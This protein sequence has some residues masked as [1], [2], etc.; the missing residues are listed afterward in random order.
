MKQ[1]KITVLALITIVSFASCSDDD[2]VAPPVNEEEVITTVTVTFTPMNGGTAVVLT[3][4][5]LDGDGPNAP[6]VTASGNLIAG[7]TYDGRVTFL[8]E[9][10]SPIE[11]ITEEIDAEG[12]KHQIFYQQTGL[13]DFTYLD[14]DANGNPI[15]LH[16][17]YTAPG[18]TA[19]GPLT[20]TL[21]HEPN[22]I[23]E[24][25]AQGII[26]NAGGA[27]DAEVTFN[28]VVE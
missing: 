10:A 20:V 19:N 21:R 28:V 22:K 11:D 26:T 27:T 1:F 5:D 16:F 4:R 18:I 8:N 3:S 12:D 15:G 14:E 7:I 13:G 6:V 17:I 24:G 9:L 23:A 2:S 25:V